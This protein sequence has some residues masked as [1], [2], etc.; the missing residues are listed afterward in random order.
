MLGRVLPTHDSMRAAPARD[1]DHD[2]DHDTDAAA[3]KRH[4]VG[5]TARRSQPADLF[6]FTYAGE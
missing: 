5:E 3:Q 4:P 1:T 6:T 2:T